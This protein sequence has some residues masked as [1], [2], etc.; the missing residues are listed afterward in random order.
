MVTDSIIAPDLY[1]ECE[2]HSVSLIS[3]FIYLFIYFV[4]F[5]YLFLVLK[6]SIA[7]TDCR[8]LL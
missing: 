8:G 2:I 3:L 4:F 6:V 1:S 7:L 5:N